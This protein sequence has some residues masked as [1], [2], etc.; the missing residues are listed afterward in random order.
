MPRAKRDVRAS[1]V[2]RSLGNSRRE[3]HQCDCCRR[4]NLP[5][6]AIAYIS[7]FLC[8]DGQPVVICGQCWYKLEPALDTWLKQTQA[9]REIRE[10]RRRRPRPDYD[11]HVDYPERF[12]DGPI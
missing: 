5:R 9:A 6:D 3:L 7:R 12:T 10:E 1:G 11:P 4:R 2:Q 8:T